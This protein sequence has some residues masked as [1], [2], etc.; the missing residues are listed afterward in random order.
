[1]NASTLAETQLHCFNALEH[2]C[3]FR[4][5]TTV[6]QSWHARR[7][8]NEGLL[9]LSILRDDVRLRLLAAWMKTGEG[10]LEF[11]AG[12]LPESSAELAVCRFEKLYLTAHNQADAFEAPDPERFGPSEKVQRGT[13]AGVICLRDEPSVLV[14]PGLRSLCQIASQAE[15]RVWDRVLGP[16][17]VGN[18][19]E[20]GCERH[21]IASL[22]QSGA[23]EYA[24]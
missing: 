13:H 24:C 12:Q 14:A 18:L 20:Q 19:M 8:V 3:G 4:F 10:L 15:L 7:A 17:R 22:L 11:I 16:T 23:L 6:Q 1:M 21:S 2:C 9:T 5:P